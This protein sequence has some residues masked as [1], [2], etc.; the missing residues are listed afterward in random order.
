MKILISFLILL[1]SIESIILADTYVRGYTKS[2]GTY[3]APHYRSDANNTKSDNW[4]TRG[5]KNPYTGKY[6]TKK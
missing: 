2:N 3:V 6:G 4:S 1:S 5:N